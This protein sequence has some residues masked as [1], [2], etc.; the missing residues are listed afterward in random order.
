VQPN[1]VVVS[2]SRAS[3]EIDGLTS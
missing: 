1:V 3:R 2:C